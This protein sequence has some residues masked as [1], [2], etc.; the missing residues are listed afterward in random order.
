MDR[1]RMIAS[2]G[3]FASSTRASAFLGL[4]GDRVNGV[5]E[6]VAFS[7]GHVREG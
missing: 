6:E 5:L 4:L 7:A 3:T 1:D 2:S